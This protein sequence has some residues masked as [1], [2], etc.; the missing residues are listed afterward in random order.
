V[1]VT[2]QL[3]TLNRRIESISYHQDKEAYKYLQK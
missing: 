3:I 1:D 2:P